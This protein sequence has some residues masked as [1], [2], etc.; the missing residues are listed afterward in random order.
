V[1]HFTPLDVIRQPFAFTQQR[2]MDVREFERAAGER[3]V[4]LSAADLERLHRARILVPLFAVRRP[5]WDIHR[6]LVI[7]DYVNWTSGRTWNV[8]KDGH[9]LLE[10]LDAGLVRIGRS[11]RFRPWARER[12]GTPHGAIARREY[13]FS[14]YQLLGL[15][16]IER[17]IPILR[18]QAS[19]MTRWERRELR[20]LR[21]HAV[22]TDELVAL[23]DA[24]EPRYLP[25][26]AR[27]YRSRI[28]TDEERTKYEREFDPVAVLRQSGWST[29]E[30][31]EAAA[32]LMHGADKHD[33]LRHWLDLVK[34]VHP[35][36]WQRLRGKALLAIGLRIA[37]EIAFRFLEDLQD[38]G[39]APAF[40]VVP[41]LVAHELNSRLLRDR[42]ELDPVLM[43]F[44]L[45]PY[46]AVV[47]ALEGPTEMEIV[48]LVM[49]V[50]GIPQRQS[51]IRLVDSGS[52]ARDHGFLAQYV[53]LPA[54]GPR[55]GN[56]AP[57]ERPP[58]H[59]LIAVDGDR[60]FRDLDARERERQKWVGVLYHSLPAEY[61]TA[62]ARDEIE[63]LVTLE[64]WADGLDFERAHFAD[65]E[66]AA[67]LV[68]TGLVP[69]S[70]TDAGL[71]ARLGDA[72]RMGTSL[73][74]VWAD[75][76]DKP[77]KPDVARLAWPALHE[78]IVGARSNDERLGQIP[79][80]RVL[81][82]AFDMAVRTPRRHVVFRVGT[83][84]TPDDAPTP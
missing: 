57:F 79:V 74:T 42:S 10:D 38:A 47:L 13:L 75:W 55:E 16:A 25:D 24:L 54:L 36:K 17:A 8:P 46:P 50:I 19:E 52:E 78:R 3:G 2:L 64:V 7:A 20:H 62:A 82:K 22:L 5:R 9:S 71:S 48:P 15:P 76:P 21:E 69:T 80:A 61:Q 41:K 65:A 27:H 29:D 33:P 35:D 34:Q 44:D 51:F 39:V 72:R 73:K 53:A 11:V 84:T 40:P 58:T 31:Y 26:I 59:Y 60:R 56:I 63:S 30:V 23:L 66:L 14:P 37:G 67:S 83:P 77:R 32:G 45:S 68:A 6:R 4:S 28:G 1:N 81:L 12:V 43:D 18:R 70:L 49:E